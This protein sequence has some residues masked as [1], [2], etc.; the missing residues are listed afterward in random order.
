MNKN[1]ITKNYSLEIE[2]IEKVKNEVKNAEIVAGAHVT[3][4]KVVNDLILTGGTF[5][6]VEAAQFKV[7]KLQALVELRTAERNEA[8][9]QL[10]RA[11]AQLT[12]TK[13]LA[14]IRLK[15]VLDKG[16][17]IKKSVEILSRS[18]ANV[19]NFERLAL[20]HSKLLNE[21]GINISASKLMEMAL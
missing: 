17:E 13:K 3:E 20:V 15:V 12:E 4:S 2:A 18:T 16:E 7:K 14:E 10:V 21:R 11:L 5:L 9:S 1:K 6:T 19:S 8:E